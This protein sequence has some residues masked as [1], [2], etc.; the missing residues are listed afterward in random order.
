MKRDRFERQDGFAGLIHRFNVFLKAPRGVRRAELAVGVYDDIYAIDIPYL[1]PANVA[2]NYLSLAS[3]ASTIAWGADGNN[4]IGRS[5][6]SAGFAANGDVVATR[7]EP[8]CSLAK[9][10]V[11]GTG[12]VAQE[13]RDTD[14]GVLLP[15]DVLLDR[16]AEPVAVLKSLVMFSISACSPIA[17]LRKPVVCSNGARNVPLRRAST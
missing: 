3:K 12:Y 13:R 14:R 5:L 17:V 9:G 8:E 1:N 4:V 15:P 2:D 11:V 7:A 6:A 16:A 10:L